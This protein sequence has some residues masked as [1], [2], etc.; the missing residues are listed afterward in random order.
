MDYCRNLDGSST[1]VRVDETT[2]Q[3]CDGTLWTWGMRMSSGRGWPRKKR[4]QHNPKS[5]GLHGSCQVEFNFWSECCW[6][7]NLQTDSWL[8]HISHICAIPS[9]WGRN[10]RVQNGSKVLAITPGSDRLWQTFLSDLE[11]KVTPTIW[12]Y[13]CSKRSSHSWGHCKRLLPQF[14]GSA[15]AIQ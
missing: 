11:E 4:R 6:L 8:Y 5:R 13:A 9:S 1:C 2:K 12:P 14:C 7:V 10:I 3:M 15:P